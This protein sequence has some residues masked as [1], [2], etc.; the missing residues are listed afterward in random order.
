MEEKKEYKITLDEFWASRD[1]GKSI[2]I[3]CDTEEKARTLLT[4][5]DKMGET[6]GNG[7]QGQRYTKKT[8]WRDY[9][10]DTVYTN[11]NFCSPLYWAYENNVP[12]YEF[13]E[14]DL[15]DYLNKQYSITLDEFWRRRLFRDEGWPYR[16]HEIF[17]GIHCDT[18]EKARTLLTAFDKMGERWES[19]ERYTENTHWEDFH[20]GT[21][22]LN[23]NTHKNLGWA[24][25][26]SYPRRA[27]PVYEFEEV[28]LTKYLDNDNQNEQEKG[29]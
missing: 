22:Y 19:G 6:W 5:F 2:A 9:Y 25:N 26:R 7:E 27:V 20:T 28:D 24:N 23:H 14:V 8:G 21:L 10:T 18:E 11:Y 4:A 29:E 17:I 3:H 16:W 15:Q 1:R 12:V 13:E